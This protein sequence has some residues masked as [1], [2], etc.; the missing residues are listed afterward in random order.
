MSTESYPFTGN[1]QKSMSF[2]PV[3]DGSVYDAQIKWNIAAQRWYLLITDS[4]GKSILNSALVGSTN[5]TGINLL[6]GVFS[7]T[8]MIWREKDGII[9]VT[10]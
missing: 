1:E 9:E 5:G 3:L 2:T 6:T 7:S 4:S 8:T 10:S